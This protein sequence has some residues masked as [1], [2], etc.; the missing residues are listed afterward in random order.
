MFESVSLIHH[1]GVLGKD[2]TIIIIKFKVV[3]IFAMIYLIS[4]ITNL[5]QILNDDNNDD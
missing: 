5:I 4:D 2:A 1:N 3:F